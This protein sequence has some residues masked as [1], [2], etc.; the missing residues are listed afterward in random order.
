MLYIQ[1]NYSDLHLPVFKS[2]IR[3]DIGY[4]DCGQEVTYGPDW[5]RGGLFMTPVLYRLQPTSTMGLF[6]YEYMSIKNIRDSFVS[7][8]QSR[9]IK[10]ISTCVVV[11]LTCAS[12]AAFYL[13]DV[14][15]RRY[16]KNLPKTSVPNEYSRWRCTKILIG[17]ISKLYKIWPKLKAITKK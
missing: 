6:T 3:H 1:R 2:S 16:F 10:K 8:P 14:K 11:F 4:Y 12:F 7:I 17:F 13:A 9:V 5:F 15:I